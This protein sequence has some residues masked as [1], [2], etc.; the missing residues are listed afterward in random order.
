M[1][2]FLFFSFFFFFIFLTLSSFQP[3][4]IEEILKIMSPHSIFLKIFAKP[5]NERGKERKIGKCKEGIRDFFSLV[6]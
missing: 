4:A 5:Q 3:Q 2:L 1:F 6:Y